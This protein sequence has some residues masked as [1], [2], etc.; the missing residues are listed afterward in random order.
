MTDKQ[1]ERV[2]LAVQNVLDVREEFPDA[3]LADLD[4][5]LSMPAKLVKAHAA[6]DK[7]VD[8]CY[9]SQPFPTER[10]RIEYLFELYKQLTAPLIPNRKKNPPQKRQKVGLGMP[11][12][13]QS[14]TFRAA[15]KS[16][17]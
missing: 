14:I 13:E 5:P 7:A 17:R 1:R 15:M 12:V 11:I 4:S 6:L 10:H 2:E 3:T 9:R 8:R 16:C